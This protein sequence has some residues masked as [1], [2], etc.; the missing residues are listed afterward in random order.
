MWAW[1]VPRTLFSTDF[2]IQR[3]R[4]K[5]FYPNV[6][7]R[8]HIIRVRDW[9]HGYSLALT[10]P[11]DVPIS[12]IT[13]GPHLEVLACIEGGHPEETYYSK[14]VS[15]KNW[16]PEEAQVR[17]KKTRMLLAQDPELLFSEVKILENGNLFIHDGY[18]RAA[19]RAE[20]G[21]K[22]AQV[23]ITISLFLT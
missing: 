19:V 15:E 1:K 9:G 2:H 16:D 6:A 21:L 18:H 11:F 5:Y 12:D 4:L 22:T 3:G 10:K 8:P 14:L 23:Q 20:K 7:F 17:R 13:T